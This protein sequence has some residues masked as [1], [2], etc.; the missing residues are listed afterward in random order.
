VYKG[1]LLL[2]RIV[3]FA[4]V[5]RSSDLVNLVYQPKASPHFLLSHRQIESNL[6]RPPCPNLTT[7]YVHTSP[8]PQHFSQK[9]YT[10][11]PGEICWLEVPVTNPSRAMA[12]YRAVFNWQPVHADGQPTPAYMDGIE[13]V[14]LFSKGKLSGAF[15]KLANNSDVASVADVKSPARSAVLPYLMVEDVDAA[16]GEVEKNGG[17]VHVYVFLPMVV[18]AEVLT[19]HQTEDTHCWG[20]DGT[21]CSVHRYRGELGCDLGPA[22]QRVKG[23]MTGCVYGSRRIVS[24]MESCYGFFLLP[25]VCRSCSR[26]SFSSYGT[27]DPKISAISLSTDYDPQVLHSPRLTRTQSSLIVPA[28]HSKSFTSKYTCALN[29]VHTA[30]A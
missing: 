5:T 22:C 9:Q 14:Y 27:T 1:T 20:R 24:W 17:Q 13:G 15:L 3:T 29:L 26:G 7:P 30:P 18:H 23:T 19:R 10:N 21:V 4:V 25:S 12:F 6:G 28:A 2:V 16:L 11:S 8:F